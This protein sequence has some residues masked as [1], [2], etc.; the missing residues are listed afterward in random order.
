VEGNG[1]GLIL[2]TIPAFP[3]DTEENHE[4]PVRIACLRA[5]I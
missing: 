5:K 1:R 4:K 3:G 2:G